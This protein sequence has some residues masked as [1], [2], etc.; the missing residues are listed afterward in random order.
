MTIIVKGFAELGSQLQ[1]IVSNLQGTF[2]SEVLEPTLSTAA[3]QAQAEAPVRTGYLRDHTGYRIL[4]D[5]EGELF[6]DADYAAPVNFGTSKNTR[7]TGF[8]SNA[9]AQLERDVPVAAQKWWKNALK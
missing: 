3:S 1:R 2:R 9:A 6:S 8:F 7:G 5:T 4:S